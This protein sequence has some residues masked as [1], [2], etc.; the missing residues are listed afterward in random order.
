MCYLR[1]VIEISAAPGSADTDSQG[2]WQRAPSPVVFAVSSSLRIV[3]R[4]LEVLDSDLASRPEHGA[5]KAQCLEGDRAEEAVDLR[6]VVQG[7]RECG[8]GADDNRFDKMS[9]VPIVA[10]GVQ[11]LPKD[12]IVGAT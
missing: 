8:Q 11:D 1:K 10:G 6:N 4:I 2:G 7:V 3:L 5:G 9:D 12:P